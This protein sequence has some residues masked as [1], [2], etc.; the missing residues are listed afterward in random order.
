MGNKMT[1]KTNIAKSGE[2]PTIKITAPYSSLEY[3]RIKA[4]KVNKLDNSV[5]W[6]HFGGGN[7]FRCFHE[8]IQ[9]ELIDKGLS[10]S[11]MALIETYDDE[12][13]DQIYHK[14][15]NRTLNVI[16]VGDGSYGLEVFDCVNPALFAGAKND[17]E[18]A[19]NLFAS[20]NLQ[21]ATITVTEKGYNL[22]GIDGN[23]LEIVKQDMAAGPEKSSGFIARLL[24]LM[25]WRFVNG[26]H[27]IALCS[28][29]N[30][31]R[32]GDKLKDSLLQIADVWQK[33][34]FVDKDFLEYLNDVQKVAYPLSMIDRITP[35]PSEK[36]V[37]T[38]SSIGLEEM[39]I[40]KTSKN[41]VTAPFTNTELTH[42]LVVE[43]NFP[44]GR[45]PFE[46][47]GVIMT[48]KEKV[49][50]VERMKVCTCLNPLHT[51][52][53]ILGCLLKFVSISDEMKDNDLVKLIKRIGYIEG[54]PVVTDPGI[55]N[56]KKFIDEV[57][58]ERLP[59][60]NIP[61]TPQRIA[62]DTS[63]KIPIRF[64]QTIL[65]YKEQLK[66][67]ESLKGIA[68]TLAA[69]LRY[70]MRLDD[71]GKPFALSPD[72]A[73]ENLRQFVSSLRLG[74]D[75]VDSVLPLLHDKA[76]FAVDL[77]QVKNDKTSLAEMV[78]NFLKKMLT[79]GENGVGGVRQTLSK[80]VN[81]NFEPHTIYDKN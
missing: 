32:N 7:L 11:P 22:K 71:E 10:N 4:P 54:L 70:L 51:S 8:Q 3:A 47:A 63:Q 14:F 56:P 23:Y 27:P 50:E 59:N 60:P 43:D 42:Y 46:K 74:S 72:P 24:A 16:L 18:A 28:T 17:W 53:A 13:I 73:E 36:F 67:I 39:G 61:D 15:K 21:L 77:Y 35:Q 38:L 40:I 19:K 25:Y 45:P 80:L 26:A 37:K 44:N 79:S 66:D 76:I 65:L 2:F 6:V 34:G 1:G 33:K 64:G 48:S 9:Q 57:I 78:I 81:N 58:Y 69:W 75:N 62:A 52:L 55:I 41:T 30:F 49:D 20:S 29:D 5:N 68:F 12:L 31:S